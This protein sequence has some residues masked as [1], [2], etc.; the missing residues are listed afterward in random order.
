M[1]R[2]IVGI[3]G[4]DRQESARTNVECQ[5]FM[6]DAVVGQRCHKVWRE[7]KRCRWRGNRPFFRRKH[8]LIIVGIASVDGALAGDIGRE[9]H[10]SCTFEQGFDRF[11]P[12]KCQ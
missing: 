1:H 12:R 7:V 2:M 11:V 9:R 5:R 6:R 4:L 3:V 10:C 8:R